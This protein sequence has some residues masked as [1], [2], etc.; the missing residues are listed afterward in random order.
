MK[1]TFRIKQ[2]GA[3][4]AVS[5][6]FVTST[7]AESRPRNE[8]DWRRAER[9]EERRDDRRDDRRARNLS[10]Q[11]RVTNL[12]R[13]RD[14]Y[15]L[16]LDRGSQ[17]YYVPSSAWRG[18]NRGLSIGLNIRLGGGYYGDRGYIYV[19]NADIYD[20]YGYG[21]GRGN[22]YVSG[23][24]QRIDHRRDVMEIR[25]RRSGRHIT[26]DARRADR[27]RHGID[28]SDIRR[29]DYVEL[30]GAWVRGNVFQAS[31][32]DALDSRR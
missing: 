11:G 12:H 20:N 14:G 15:R 10:A 28:V 29:G 13:E 21:R 27:R 17:W 30:E 4:L 19:S 32:I 5:T 8:A 16:Q 25:D 2:F 22:G 6:L 1:Q 7:F 31:R 18:H 26:V 23:V 9:R 24:V 3:V